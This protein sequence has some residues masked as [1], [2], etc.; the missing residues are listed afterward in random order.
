MWRAL[1]RSGNALCAPLAARHQCY[2]VLSFLSARKKLVPR[3]RHAPPPPLPPAQ[4]LQIQGRSTIEYIDIKPQLTPPA[5]EEPVTLVFLHGAPGSYQ[6]FRYLIPLVRQPGVR[7][8][9]LNLPGYEGSTVVKTRFLEDISA[10]PTAELV[11][12]AVR[13]LC[14]DQEASNNVFLVGHSFGAHTAINITALNAAE[15]QGTATTAVSFRGLALLAPVGCSPH[16]VMRPRA[17]ALV[18]RMLGSRNPL[19]A[20]VT[21]HLVKAIYTKLL[22]FPRDSPPE[23]FVAAVVRAG[24]TDFAVIRQQVA[25]LRSLRMPMLVAWAQNDEYVQEEIP[26]ELARLCQADVRLAF[27]DGG[28]NIQKTRAEQVAVA[29]NKWVEGVLSTSSDEGLREQ[30][31]T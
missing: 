21:P 28:H 20:G 24:T 14:G 10:L 13:Q 4:Y 17:N 12:D 23:P 6:D 11:L 16:H 8:L 3:E 30:R 15:T 22:R 27:V 25:A 9:G 19:L 2:S 7:I 26:T 18:I 29:M 5:L 1:H 31:K